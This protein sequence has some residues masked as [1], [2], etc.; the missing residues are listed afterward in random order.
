MRRIRSRP[1]NPS[2]T[3]SALP[4]RVKREQLGTRPVG[5]TRAVG[6]EQ[7]G[8]VRWYAAGTGS[9]CAPA[10]AAGFQPSPLLMA[11]ISS[12]LVVSPLS[13]QKNEPPRPCCLA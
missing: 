10:P 9:G 12:P 13:S 11:E 7:V 1:G 2:E 3:G 8:V 5:G 4:G 6:D